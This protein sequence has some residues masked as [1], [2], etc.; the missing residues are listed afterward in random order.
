MGGVARRARQGLA[1]VVAPVVLR[2]FP[3]L[4]RRSTKVLLAGART[5]GLEDRAALPLLREAQ[6]RFRNGEPERANDILGVIGSSA[7]TT[8]PAPSRVVDVRQA[9][10]RTLIEQIQ[11]H[12]A[13]HDLE[14]ARQLAERAVEEHPDVIRFTDLLLS[15]LHEMGEADRALSLAIHNAERR[16]RR[17]HRLRDSTLPARRLTRDTRILISGYFYSGS[18][19]VLDYLRDFPG[20][21]KWTPTGE[22]RL[23]KFPGGLDDLA[24]R[25]K[26]HG[27]LTASD[28]VDLYLHVTGWKVTLS[29]PGTY[30]QWA[31]VNRN[32]RR[33]FRKPVAFGY[34]AALLECFREL[35][36]T[37]TVADTTAG[38]EEH[39][40]NHLERALDAAATDAQADLLLIDQAITAWRFD[41]GRLVPPSTF[42]SV[43]RDPRDQYV[44]VREVLEQPG[45]RQATAESFAKR[46]RRNRDK[47]ERLTPELE[48][49]HGHRIVRVGFED[50]V[51]D[52]DRESRRLVDLLGL[53][54][55]R[56]VAGRFD[57]ER[58]RANIG[59][60]AT[61]LDD[62]DRATLEAELAE[63]L[64][65]HADWPLA[66][67]D[68]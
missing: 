5:L 24:K 15:L 38:L 56:R 63:F 17:L 65:P 21:V 16:I 29:P 20:T 68:R 59:K 9:D 31:I 13:G 37:P 36:T 52:H 14:R 50:F 23:L 7:D 43:H 32:S 57:P 27:A 3:R 46:N 47:V 19:A 54:P 55:D 44:E 39:F 2:L 8:S 6:R 12:I 11:A 33:M 10:A 60:H 25:H 22:M 49:D 30:D 34:L 18:G 67:D 58:S 61:L 62:R 40:R 51:M 45:R 4:G 1:R 64:S 53:D 26:E 35:A 66:H 28:L 48:R 41:L 42:I